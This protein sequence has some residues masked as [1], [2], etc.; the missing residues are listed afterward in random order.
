MENT[1]YFQYINDLVEGKQIGG[2]HTAI[3]KYLIEW[4][5]QQPY[6]PNGVH[7]L[8]IYFSI[9]NPLEIRECF[10]VMIQSSFPTVREFLFR[11]I[12][13][14]LLHQ[15]ALIQL[16]VI[17]LILLG[18]KDDNENV[19]SKA[20]DILSELKFES[21]FI[22]LRIIYILNDIIDNLLMSF[23][24][25]SNSLNNE[26]QLNQINNAIVKLISITI[27]SSDQPKYSA[28]KQHLESHLIRFISN[29]KSFSKLTVFTYYQSFMDIS[30][31]SLLVMLPYLTEDRALD[32]QK[33]AQISIIINSVF[34][35]YQ[36]SHRIEIDNTIHNLLHSTGEPTPDNVKILYILI[37]TI[38]FD[39]IFKN[40]I[41]NILKYFKKNLMAIDDWTQIANYKRLLEK[42]LSAIIDSVGGLNNEIFEYL[43]KDPLGRVSNW[44]CNLFK[45][46]GQYSKWFSPLFQQLLDTENY[47]G[48][49]SLIIHSTNKNNMLHYKDFILPS[50]ISLLKSSKQDQL[51][52]SLIHIS[53]CSID[54]NE[55]L[56]T[57]SNFIE[58]EF[59]IMEYD[60]LDTN[61]NFQPIIRNLFDLY[62]SSGHQ[63]K[64]LEKLYGLLYSF[65]TNRPDSYS[66][67]LFTEIYKYCMN[68]LEFISGDLM[69]SRVFLSI[70][71]QTF[72]EY[73]ERQSKSV[74]D[75]F[76]CRA[77]VELMRLS[78][79]F[80]L[81]YNI[82][83]MLLKYMSE[84]PIYSY[85]H[86]LVTVLKI[87]YKLSNY[88][89]AILSAPTKLDKLILNI[90]TQEFT[91][92]SPLNN[93]DG[94]LVKYFCKYIVTYKTTPSEV[95]E[96]IQ[97][98]I[99][100]FNI[101]VLLNH[102]IVLVNI[103]GI[104]Q[105]NGSLTEFSY[106][107][108]FKINW[109]HYK[110]SNAGTT[111]LLQNLATIESIIPPSSFNNLIND[112][113][114]FEP[115]HKYLI[116]YT[117][118]PRTTDVNPTLPHIVLYQIITECLKDTTINWR[119]IYSISFVS[120]SFFKLITKLSILDKYMK[121]S[122][123]CKINLDS[124]YSIISN[125][126]SE[127]LINNLNFY[128]Q[129][130]F[131]R[132]LST[133]QT[134]IIKD[135]V[136]FNFINP[137]YTDTI[138]SL[139]ST[140]LQKLVLSSGFAQVIIMGM[141]KKYDMSYY[142]FVGKLLKSIKHSIRVDLEL[143]PSNVDVVDNLIECRGSIDKVYVTLQ[144]PHYQ[145]NALFI[146][147]IK[148]LSEASIPL[149]LNSIVFTSAIHQMD[150]YKDILK[151]CHSLEIIHHGQLKPGPFN[152]LQHLKLIAQNIS[153]PIH[154]DTLIFLETTDTLVSLTLQNLKW[155]SCVHV[156]KT[157]LRNP[158]IPLQTLHIT[159]H[160]LSPYEIQQNFELLCSGYCKYPI[161]DNLLQ[162]LP[163]LN[164][165]I[166]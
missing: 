92:D 127:V 100:V 106:L 45:N 160:K 8:F 55:I 109:A 115:F 125:P 75:P 144:T 69:L 71:V 116:P 98:L 25:K 130:H 4:I 5:E 103:I 39:I 166:N 145:H 15:K 43:F 28:E 14:D 61:R 37:S 126:S 52:L 51:I 120:K 22:P 12:K 105:S 129:S 67:S 110:Y 3:K 78:K 132:I 159:V 96:F 2:E 26:K 21:I 33:F 119:W 137:E 107:E 102:P 64:I 83:A 30:L 68:H 94:K 123:F 124:P 11:L 31:S 35:K 141:G 23:I 131:D 113:K 74:N 18:V 27:L 53:S 89:I 114:P 138:V 16:E 79:I 44:E 24:N 56:T 104:L 1:G 93:P 165:I 142:T 121:E 9:K 85:R 70:S 66:T 80:N 99:Q 153:L 29:I 88:N 62:K 118:S 90:I 152:A 161:I 146:S 108:L 50:I 59:N 135:N 156:I 151:F 162:F 154:Q 17:E 81:G 63:P 7:N 77:L 136:T 128:Q 147:T 143:C 82:R 111:D 76:Y 41:F 97:M 49:N 112:L 58:L 48:I 139:V 101:G 117:I 10:S 133:A 149:E 95:S 60:N 19:F 42:N 73:M 164:I 20:L 36:Q 87:L 46:D 158:K 38:D 157:L 163:N 13:R 155:D 40:N 86:M 57:I 34:T 134:L 32:K 72:T 91:K 54:S 47:D 150:I 122:N 140:N 6:L 148:R 65:S 84:I